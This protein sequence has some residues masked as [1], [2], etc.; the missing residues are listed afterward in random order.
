VYNQARLPNSVAATRSKWRL[1]PDITMDA[2]DGTPQAATLLAGVLALATQLNY[3]GERRPDQQTCSTRC[4]GRLGSGTDSRRRVGQQHAD[5]RRQ[6]LRDLT[7]PAAR[8]RSGLA[9]SPPR[10]P[11]LP[12]AA[13]QDAAEG[14]AALTRLQHQE[15]LS[16]SYVG[17]G[18]TTLLSGQ[19]FLPGHPVRLYIDARKIAT[20]RADGHGSVSYVIKPSHSGYG[21]A[22]TCSTWSAC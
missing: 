13:H 20:L 2:S 22:G 17:R 11:A 16:R 6:G 12:Q 3:G 8:A 15:R 7:S 1:V 19:G 10:W 5:R 18:A 9:R 14:A 21:R 4:S